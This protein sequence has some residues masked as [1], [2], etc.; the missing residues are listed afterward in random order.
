MDNNEAEAKIAALERILERERLARKEAEK[1]LEDYTRELYQQEEAVNHSQQEVATQQEQLEF[2]TGLLAET[3]RQPNLQK[4]VTN[5]LER[6]NNFMSNAHNLFVEIHADLSFHQFQYY[7]QASKQQSEKLPE[8]YKVVLSQLIHSKLYQQVSTENESQIFELAEISKSP[9]PY[10]SY[11]VIVPLYNLE[12]ASGKSIGIAILLYESQDDINIVK[13]QTLESSRSMLSVAIERKRAE[14]SLQE[15]LKELETTNSMLEQT[16]Q[17]LLQQE[18]LASLGQLAAGVAHEINNPIGFVLSN[19]DTLRDYFSDF[20]SILSPLKNDQ[21]NDQGKVNAMQNEWQTLDGDFLLQDSEEIL[22]SSVQGLVRVKDIVS[23]LST[24]SRMDN[25]EL[26]SIDLNDVIDKSLNVVSNEFKYHHQIV[27]DLLPYA[28]ILGNAGKLQQ[29]FINLFVNAK[30]AMP[31]GGTLTI[32]SEKERNKVIVKVID[33]GHGIDP[34]HLTNIFTPFFTTKAPGEGTGLGLAISYSILQQHNAKV[35]VNS[36][37]G[38]GT[39]FKIAF[40]ES[41]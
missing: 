3:W 22:T 1:Q 12:L 31:D 9:N 41:I 38:V 15:R 35:K 27:K 5:Y 30:H 17:Q 21:L 19:L 34:S 2:L 36:K 23:D 26:D 14:E 40:Y 4:I 18:K 28:T 6:T 13:L 25:D 33:E 37:V 8:R 20:S 11:S 29:V 32:S 10:F 16:Q 24:F 39:E 7:C